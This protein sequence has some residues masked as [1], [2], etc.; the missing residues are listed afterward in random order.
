MSSSNPLALLDAI[1]IE[2]TREAAD[3][4]FLAGFKRRDIV[5][6]LVEA[7]DRAIVLPPGKVGDA[8]EKADGPVAR[9]LIGFIVALVA[10][11]RRA[12]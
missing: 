6:M 12:P 1:D 2:A 11:K 5:D 10:K 4:L 7:A 9:A 3:A 8:I